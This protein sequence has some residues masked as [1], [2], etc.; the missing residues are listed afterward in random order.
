VTPDEIDEALGVFGRV[1]RAL[2]AH[3]ETGRI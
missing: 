2:P 1:L 3:P